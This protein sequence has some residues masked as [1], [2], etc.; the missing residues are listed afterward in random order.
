MAS[1]ARLQDLVDLLIGDTKLHICIHDV[2]GVLSHP[3]MSLDGANRVHSRPFCDA[4]KGSAQGLKLCMRCKMLANR[5]AFTT[6]LPFCGDCPNGLHEIVLP[7]WAEDTVLCIVYIGNLVCDMEQ[8]KCN[9]Q[10]A[11]A[12]TGIP[13]ER[14]IAHLSQ[15]ELHPKPDVYYM[16]MANL[17]R[18]YILLMYNTIAPEVKQSWQKMHWVVADMK[19]Y[20]DVHYGKVLSLRQ[21]AGMYFFN[22]NYLGRLFQAQTGQ[23]F[24]QYLNTVRLQKAAA[25]LCNTDRTATDIALE[26]GFQTVAYFDRLFVKQYGMAP[27]AYRR[28]AVHSEKDRGY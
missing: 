13:A 24:R 14:M 2:S 1:F 9:L 10:K 7:V 15:V 11:A 23:T 21:L 4:A 28:A 19:A 22:A 3:L 16:E 27:L 6:K 18:S 17:I 8:C 12:F 5:R 25:L 20:M 26:C